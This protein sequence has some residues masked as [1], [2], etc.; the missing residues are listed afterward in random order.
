MLKAGQP[1]ALNVHPWELD[2]DQPR[3]P[4][5]VRTRFTHYHNLDKTE[6]RID[7]VLSE[8]QFLSIRQVLTRLGMLGADGADSAR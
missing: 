3:F 4:V 5:S 6:S 2:P 1:V 8:A 7:R